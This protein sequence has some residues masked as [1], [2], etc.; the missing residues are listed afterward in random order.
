[1]ATQESNVN[2]GNYINYI[3]DYEGGELDDNDTLALFQFLVDSGLAWS[4]QGSYGRTASALIS[5]GLIHA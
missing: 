5:N 4:L 2:A 1:M 3:M